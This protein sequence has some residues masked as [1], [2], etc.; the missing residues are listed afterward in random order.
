MPYRHLALFL[1]ALALGYLF[2]LVLVGLA[3]TFFHLHITARILPGV[4]QGEFIGT[5]VLSLAIWFAIVWICRLPQPETLDERASSYA[6]Y[7]VGVW[8]CGLFVCVVNYASTNHMPGLTFSAYLKASLAP[9]L[10]LLACGSVLW[11]LAR[12]FRGAL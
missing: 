10:L 6:G 3:G 2:T 12:R 5:T 4:T 1:R 9:T 7:P 11:L 8:C